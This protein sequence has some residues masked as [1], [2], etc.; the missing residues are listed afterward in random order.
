MENVLGFGTD[1]VQKYMFKCITNAK[2]EFRKKPS[3]TD[4]AQRKTSSER[5]QPE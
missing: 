3:Q 2:V 1:L 4:E 5:H